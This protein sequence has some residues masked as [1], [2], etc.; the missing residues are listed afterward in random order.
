MK[1]DVKL[2]ENV[3]KLMLVRFPRFASQISSAKLEYKTDLKYHTAATDGKNIYFDPEYFASLNDDDKLFITAHEFLHIKF[4]HM[5]RMTD[6]NGQKRDIRLWNTATDAIIN[7]NLERDGFKIKEG[8][9]NM[10]EALNYSAEEFYEKLLAEKQEQQQSRNGQNQGQDAQNSQGQN[11]SQNK[12]QSS[13]QNN[14]EITER[15]KQESQANHEQQKSQS[16]QQSTNTSKKDKD[17]TK[18]GDFSKLIQKQTGQNMDNNTQFADDHSLWGESP[19]QENELKNGQVGSKLISNAQNKEIDEKFEFQQNRE[20]RRERAKRSIQSLW[21]QELKKLEDRNIELGDIGEEKPILDWKLL[22]RREVEK[23]D[24]I[25]SQRKSI[26]ENNYAYRL[27]EMDEDDEAETEV[28]IDVSGSVSNEMIRSFLRQLKPILKNSK[29]KVGFFADF[30]TKEFQEIK[31][32]R[33]INNLKIY[34]PGY[35]TNMDTAVRAFSKKPEVN[36]IIFTD[37]YPGQE[38]KQDLKDVNVIWLVYENK[39]FHP[40]CGKVIN[41]NLKDFQDLNTKRKTDELELSK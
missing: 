39:D 28:M 23:T 13:E 21:N 32:D 19:E 1:Y 12:N 10:P 36:K 8:Y 40:C 7:A 38:P 4:E 33:D 35:G 29:L 17:S 15:S 26:A 22:L 30:A 11:T 2:L 25:W 41:V 3:K 20:E 27:E 34:R 9:V 14:S 6:K 18:T 5:F 31:K 37:G 16:D 24:T